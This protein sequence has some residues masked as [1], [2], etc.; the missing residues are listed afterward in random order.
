[1]KIENMMRVVAVVALALGCTD[2]TKPVSEDVAQSS[3][4]IWRGTDDD[5]PTIDPYRNA[6]VQIT[7]PGGG[8][9][10]G[11]YVT[12]QLIVTAAHC[13]VGSNVGG[14]VPGGIKEGATVRIGRDRFA[15]DDT[16]RIVQFAFPRLNRVL[17]RNDYEHDIA[18]MGA[19]PPVVDIVYPQKPRFVVP[20]LSNGRGVFPVMFGG[21]GI[22]Q[23]GASPRFRQ[24]QFLDQSTIRRAHTE[25]AENWHLWYV[26]FSSQYNGPDSGDSGG[27]LLWQYDPN[28]EN[29][30]DLLGDLAQRDTDDDPIAVWTDVL[31]NEGTPCANDRETP[32]SFPNSDWGEKVSDGC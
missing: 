19:W 12:S 16:T 8:A 9:C 28:D 7:A 2:G 20:P 30:W 26:N 32:G 3:E 13:V 25:N 27:P 23:T 15:F 24:L 10:T 17:T 14:G 18:L 22:D 1:M 5:G 31:W 4:A 6:I 21:Y 11:F 29:K